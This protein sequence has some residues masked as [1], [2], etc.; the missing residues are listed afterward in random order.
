MIDK[1]AS[2]SCCCFFAVE[3]IKDTRDFVQNMI[4]SAYC[5]FDV[6]FITFCIKRQISGIYLLERL[7]SDVVI[8]MKAG[9]DYKQYISL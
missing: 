1:I 6:G 7:L 2:R 9:Y 5:Y 4:R 3:L 8:Q